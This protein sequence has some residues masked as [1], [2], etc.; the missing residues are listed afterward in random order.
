MKCTGGDMVGIQCPHDAKWANRN[1]VK[2][3]EHHK[4]LLVAFAWEN[5]NTRKWTR[6]KGE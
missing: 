4:L 6:I 5:R 3:C 1:G 2:V